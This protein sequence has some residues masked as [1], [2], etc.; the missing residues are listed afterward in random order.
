MVNLARRKR[1]HLGGILSLDRIVEGLEDD[2]KHALIVDLMRWG[3]SWHDIGTIDLSWVEMKAI[4]SQRWPDTYL[5]SAVSMELAVAENATQRLLVDIADS[6]RGANWQRGGGGESNRPESALTIFADK[7]EKAKQD[8]SQMEKPMPA[9][10]E[11]MEAIKEE[12]AR[13]RKSAR[14]AEQGNK[15]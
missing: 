9:T 11:T 1:S 5:A 15:E 4:F 14:E 7:A 2:K 12:L 3:K 6:L 13:R 10:V 8:T